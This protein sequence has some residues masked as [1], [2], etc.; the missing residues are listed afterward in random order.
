MFA[1]I[2]IPMDRVYELGKAK[3]ANMELHTTI[4]NKKN[5]V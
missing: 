3:I 5:N 1:R 2:K 4:K